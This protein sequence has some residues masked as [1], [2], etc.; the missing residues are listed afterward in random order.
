[1]TNYSVPFDFDGK[2][3]LWVEFESEI[4]RNLCVFYFETKSTIK[5][6]LN[7]EF[8]H[9]SH[10]KL[11]GNNKL[12][13]VR[14]QNLVEIREIADLKLN[15]HFNNIGEEVIAIDIYVNQNKIMMNEPLHEANNL[16]SNV[17][18]NNLNVNIQ[19]NETHY[20]KIENNLKKD[21]VNVGIND[22][23]I[24]E[25]NLSIVLLDVD[26]NVNVWENCNVMTKFNLYN[27]ND[28]GIDYKNKQFFS[29]GYPYYI[30]MNSNYFAVSTDHGV[31]VIKKA[32]I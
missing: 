9:I 18:N 20:L 26:G 27:L 28:M 6:K 4:S 31:F 8:G 5:H 15:Q 12:V 25:D 17:N 23:N 32:E 14:L 22:D 19:K 13:L 7:K 10:C 30:K 16:N 24:M 3:F 11:L 29:M 1:M 2:K 21:H